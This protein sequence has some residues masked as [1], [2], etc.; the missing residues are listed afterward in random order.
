MD[1]KTFV[2][3]TLTQIVEGVREAQ[4]RTKDSGAAV[5]PRITQST[6]GEERRM[7]A[8]GHLVHVIDFDVA[9]SATEGTGTKGGVGVVVGAF[10]LG[11]TGQ[12]Q[13]QTSASSRIKFT[14]PLVLPENEASVKAVSRSANAE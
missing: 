11:T 4:V 8:N 3:E 1:L 14:V 7:I 2:A 5:S 13:T 6:R 10:T 12:S 9:L